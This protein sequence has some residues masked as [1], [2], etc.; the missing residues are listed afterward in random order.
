MVFTSVVLFEMVRV[1]MI[2]SSYGKMFNNK[3]LGLAVAISV[4]LQLIV[5]YTPLNTYFKAVALTGMDWMYIGGALVA[6]AIGGRSEEHTSE[7][8]SQFHLVCRLLLEK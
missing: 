6:F 1:Y 4:I 3:Y 5:L 7:L 2:K 8:Q